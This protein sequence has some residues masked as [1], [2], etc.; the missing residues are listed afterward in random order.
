MSD[1]SGP[2]NP[3]GSP[4]LPPPLPPERSGCLTAFMVIFGIVLL[5]PG[6]C[7]ALFS[8]SAIYGGQFRQVL[9]GSPIIIIG[10][11][12]GFAGIMLIRAASQGS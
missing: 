1:D 4:P 11:L 2:V 5:L 7:A 3:D 12:V 6:L 8:V 9:D 10:L